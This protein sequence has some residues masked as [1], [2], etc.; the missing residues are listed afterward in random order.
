MVEALTQSIT[1][2][3]LQMSETGPRSLIAGFQLLGPVVKGNKKR[4]LCLHYVPLGKSFYSETETDL[5][6]FSL[7]NYY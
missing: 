7:G 2:T 4:F 5:S 3:V 6:L 1:I